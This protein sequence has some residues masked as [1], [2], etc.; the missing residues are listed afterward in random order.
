MGHN[1]RVDIDDAPVVSNVAVKNA[2][3]ILYQP[4]IAQLVEHLTVERGSNQMVPGSIP[5]GR[6]SSCGDSHYIVFGGMNICASHRLD[7]QVV[8]WPNG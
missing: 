6:R 4:A 7:R 2:V 1:G 5:G 8:L 3:Y